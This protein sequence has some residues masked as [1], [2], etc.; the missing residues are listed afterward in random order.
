MTLRSPAY[1]YSDPS[2]QIQIDLWLNGSEMVNGYAI[3]SRIYYSRRGVLVQRR[4]LWEYQF[5]TY[6]IC[7]CK[8]YRHYCNLRSKPFPGELEAFLVSHKEDIKRSDK[9]EPS[10]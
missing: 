1:T 10:I 2:G 4:T 6:L 5:L 7:L 8:V 3:D 9:F